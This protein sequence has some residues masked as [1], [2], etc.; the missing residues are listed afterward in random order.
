MSGVKCTKPIIITIASGKGGV[1][2]S[3]LAA[4][5]ALWAAQNSLPT[6]L[7]D[8][9]FATPNAHSF[10][11]IRQ[12]QSIW[13]FLVSP[14][15]SRTPLSHY[16]TKTA[17]TRLSLYSFGQDIRSHQL[18][19]LQRLRKIIAA[20]KQLPCKLIII[21]CGA[22]ASTS[23]AELLTQADFPLVCVEPTPTAFENAFGLIKFC[24]YRSLVKKTH[25]SPEART[26][27]IELAHSEPQQPPQSFHHVQQQLFKR[28]A[29]LH[30]GSTTPTDT[31]WYIVGNKMQ[32]ST[33]RKMLEKFCSVIA[34]HLCLSPE[35][36]GYTP[37]DQSVVQAMQHYRCA[38]A[39]QAQSPYARAIDTIGR[40][41]VLDIASSSSAVRG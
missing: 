8:A 14:G 41:L 1:G 33:H 9:D 29:D 35:I 6:A 15:A 18:I 2:K 4:N 40:A 23:I 22:G 7:F 3:C 36:A 5:L 17:D 28:F 11:G 38:L 30:A 25:R 26:H 10:F 39:E 31:K 21:D 34:K 13:P 27:L 16:A 12:P 32:A 37:L 19:S 20:L 24:R